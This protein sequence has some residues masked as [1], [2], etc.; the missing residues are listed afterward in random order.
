LAVASIGGRAFSIRAALQRRCPDLAAAA[1]QFA[2]PLL[3]WI[4]SLRLTPAYSGRMRALVYR[5]PATGLNVQGF[6]AEEAG[7]LKTTYVSID[8]PICSRP[9][10]I[11]PA[12]GKSLGDNKTSD[13]TFD[14]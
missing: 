2:G 6:L 10:L 14:K 13:N 11:N 7:D 9:H 8:C 3:I 12:T 4:I 1:V 5:C